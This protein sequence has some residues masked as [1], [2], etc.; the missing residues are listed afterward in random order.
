MAKKVR[1]R[2][3]P[4]SLTTREEEIPFDTECKENEGRLKITFPAVAQAT[5]INF[6]RQ[7]VA[8]VTVDVPP[9]SGDLYIMGPKFEWQLQKGA[10][11]IIR[12]SRNRLD[13]YEIYL[14]TNNERAM[15]FSNYADG[16]LNQ[17]EVRLQN[18]IEID[19]KIPETINNSTFLRRNT[20]QITFQF[21]LEVSAD[22]PHTSF[23]EV[24]NLNGL[25]TIRLGSGGDPVHATTNPPTGPQRG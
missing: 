5:R 4:V 10:S 13:W 20:K 7:T 21:A 23:L 2:P 24:S 9:G 6:I 1:I 14:L 3:L 12:F 17:E 22:V 11:A 18:V 8:S 16:E 25:S 19:F 15:S